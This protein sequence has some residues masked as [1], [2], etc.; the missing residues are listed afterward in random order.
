MPSVRNSGMTPPLHVRAPM[1]PQCWQP[2]IHDVVLSRPSSGQIWGSSDGKARL[3]G[4]PPCMASK[5]MSVSGAPGSPPAKCSTAA[6]LLQKF[7]DQTP[8]SVGQD[9]FPGI[10]WTSVGQ[11]VQA[12]VGFAIALP[13]RACSS[14][15]ITTAGS[16]LSCASATKVIAHVTRSGLL[17]IAIECERVV[18]L[19]SLFLLSPNSVNCGCVC[20]CVHRRGDG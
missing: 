14:C 3:P 13:S 12:P 7:A 10:C 18:T 20:M 16:V 11:C 1:L 4:S 15:V 19:I 9:R 6:D 8:D 2:C 17:H 5:V